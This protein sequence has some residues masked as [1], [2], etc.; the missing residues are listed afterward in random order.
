MSTLLLLCGWIVFAGPWPGTD[1]KAVGGGGLN[2]ETGRPPLSPQA[3]VLVWVSVVVFPH[4]LAAILYGSMASR[5]ADWSPLARYVHEMGVLVAPILVCLTFADIAELVLLAQLATVLGLAFVG[6]RLRL[7]SRRSRV[8]P[9]RTA[10]SITRASHS[11]VPRPFPG[12]VATGGRCSRCPS[13][14]GTRA[15]GTWR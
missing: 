15:C 8:L 9:H 12:S 13:S 7:T 2:G 10:P 4:V 1:D 5:P 14:P 11:L 6:V 3:F